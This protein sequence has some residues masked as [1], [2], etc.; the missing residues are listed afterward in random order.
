V[1]SRRTRESGAAVSAVKKTICAVFLVYSAAAQ[2]AGPETT[3]I[4]DRS[5]WPQTIN[6]KDSFDRASR[7]EILVFAVALT[8]VAGQPA[9]TLRTQLQINQVNSASVDRVRH[10]LMARLLE[11]WRAASASCTGN[12][13]FCG[14]ISTAGELV[15][16]GKALA[17]KPPAPY[18]AWHA[19]AQRFHRNYANELI[20]LAALF[21]VVSSEIDTF[22]FLEHSGVELPD[23]QFLLTFD[24]G[25]TG[26]NGN[27]DVLLSLLAKTD[28]HAMFYLLGERLEA[29]L[30]QD[31]PAALAKIFQGQCV[32]MHGWQH[33]SHALWEQWQGSVTDTTKLVKATF[34][35]QYRPW[36]RPPYG[37][38][39]PDSAGF[40]RK[41]GLQV[42]LW[43]IDSQDWNSHVSGENA[44]QRVMTLMLLW[45]HGVILFHDIHPKV[46]VAVPW[47]LK[48]ARMTGVTWKDCRQ[49]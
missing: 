32:A 45:R 3:A 2:T 6:S 11:N 47:L 24:D 15:A 26:K 44:A 35:Q 38:R 19:G 41:N 39:R 30:Q 33:R 14:N 23:R 42:A 25:P 1:S 31:N 17:D 49:Y 16:A 5:L 21:P 48:H 4:A 9:A 37:Q 43:N 20:R 40:F 29:R 13:S 36:F 46:Q 34:P 8:E 27:T 18:R 10:E 28:I 22:S 12:D 7:A